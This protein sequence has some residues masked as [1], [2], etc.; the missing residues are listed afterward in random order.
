MEDNKEKLNKFSVNTKQFCDI[1]ANNC[2]WKVVLPDF[3]RG[4][5]LVPSD[6]GNR[7]KLFGYIDKFGSVEVITPQVVRVQ[8]HLKESG[9]TAATFVGFCWGA[10]V[11]NSHFRLN[12]PKIGF[13]SNLFIF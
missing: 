3:F 9:V 10:K 7:E 13:V 2:G 11:R 5:Y 4:D 8:D 12:Y 6:L 1:L